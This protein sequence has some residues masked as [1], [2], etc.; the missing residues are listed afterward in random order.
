[1]ADVGLVAF[2]IFTKGGAGSQNEV[3]G[4]I[5]REELIEGDGGQFRCKRKNDYLIG[6][7]SK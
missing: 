5:L 1:M 3:R 4:G 6:K 7:R 2:P